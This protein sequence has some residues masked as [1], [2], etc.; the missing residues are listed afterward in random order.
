MWMHS[1]KALL[2]AAKVIED[3]ADMAGSGV[4]FAPPAIDLDLLRA[5]KNRVVAKLTNG[6]KVLA[7]QRKVDVVQGEAKFTGPFFPGGVRNRRRAANR[8]QAVHHRG[9]IR[10]GALPGFPTIRA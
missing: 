4:I 1:S 9:G 2:H 8:L 3:A 7:K 5:W 6:L 10:V